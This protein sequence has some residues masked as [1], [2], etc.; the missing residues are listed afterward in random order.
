MLY[1][2]VIS[3]RHKIRLPL[4]EQ[5]GKLV[6]RQ[7]IK[8][9]TS[10]RFEWRHTLSSKIKWHECRKNLRLNNFCKCGLISE[11]FS[12]GLIS[13]KKRCENTPEH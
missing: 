10:K 6:T 13:Q 7:P 4:N 8:L 9:P 5:L 1:L 2:N 3:V 11:R 12:F